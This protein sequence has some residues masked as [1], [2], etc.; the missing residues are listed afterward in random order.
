LAKTALIIAPPSMHRMR[1][2]V[3]KVALSTPSLCRRTSEPASCRALW[4]FLLREIFEDLNA[5]LLR[6]RS[7]D[8]A[9]AVPEPDDF[10]LFFDVHESTSKG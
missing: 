5:D 10:A 2:D 1:R 3:C 6:D 9:H 4:S 8:P 7:V